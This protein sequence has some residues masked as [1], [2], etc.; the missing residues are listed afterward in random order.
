ML[1]KLSLNENIHQI[2]HIRNTHQEL[3]QSFD[4]SKWRNAQQK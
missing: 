1:Y 2:K 4:F 3:I